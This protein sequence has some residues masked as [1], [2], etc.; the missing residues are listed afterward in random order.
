M[1]P[2]A[3]LNVIPRAPD[4]ATVR[5]RPYSHIVLSSYI[6]LSFIVFSSIW[7]GFCDYL[8]VAFAGFGAIAFSLQSL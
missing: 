7:V 1:L 4:G 3:L 2:V 8:G 6:F 5:P